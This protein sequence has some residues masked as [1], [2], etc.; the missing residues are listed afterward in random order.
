MKNENQK[1]QLTPA[2]AELLCEYAD[3]AGNWSGMPLVGG[4]VG[5]TKKDRGN[6]TDLKVKGFIHTFEDGRQG[7]TWVVFEKPAI[8]WLNANHP[9]EGG[10]SWLINA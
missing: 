2:S 6:L 8:D 1:I 9:R 4:N 7:S 3:D 5:G 10:W